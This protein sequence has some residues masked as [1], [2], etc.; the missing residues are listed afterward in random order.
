MFL[1]YLKPMKQW[2]FYN[3][4]IAQNILYLLFYVLYPI[5]VIVV[6]TIKHNGYSQVLKRF[7]VKPALHS[8]N[9]HDTLF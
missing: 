4:G 6:I 2:Y 5:H 7:S 3:T 1:Q 9:F 8:I